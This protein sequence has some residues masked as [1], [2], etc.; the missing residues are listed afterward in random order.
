MKKNLLII[1][2]LSCN[3]I[4]YSQSFNQLIIGANNNGAI[5]STALDGSSPAV[6]NTGQS[7]QSYYNA[8]YNP[9]DEKLYMSWYY[10]IYSMNTDG[11]DFQ[12]LYSYPAGGMGD[13]IDID[14]LNGH[15][16]FTNTTEDF[17]YRIDLD[18]GNLTS[19]YG[20]SSNVGF[21]SQVQVDIQNNHLYFGEEIVAS[22]GLYR[23]NLDGTNRQTINNTEMPFFKT[24]PV[25]G[26][27]YYCVDGDF[28][29]CNLDGSN[30]II[31]LAGQSVSAFDIDFDADK[32]YYITWNNNLISTNLAGN[33]VTVLLQ[34][35][36]LTI[37]GSNLQA[38]Q[39]PV[40]V[41][42][43]NVSAD[44]SETNV[45]CHGDTT[46][47][48]DLTVSG[49][50][51]PYSYLWDNGEI[52]E[53]LSDLSA[54]TY[55]ITITDAN[56][57]T[58]TTSV[59]LTEPTAIDLSTDLTN[60][61]CHGDT[62]GTIDLTVSGGTNPYS[63]MWDN[64]QITEDLSDLSAGT[65]EVTV[66]DDNNCTIT[67]SVTL[68]EPTAIDLSTDLTNIT[69]H[70]GTNGA[71]DLTVS[72]GT[73]PYSYLWSNDETTQDLNN[74]SAGTYDVIVTDASSCTTTTSV[75]LTE[76]TAIDISTNV[77]SITIT[78]NA[79]GVNY[80]WL[81][82]DNDNA[83]ITGATNQSFT[84]IVNGNYAVIID[85]GTCSDT[86]ACV[87]I[88]SL[89]LDEVW[90]TELVEIYPN[91]TAGDVTITFEGTIAELTIRDATGKLVWSNEIQQNTTIS[92]NDYQKG[93]YFFE[94]KTATQTGIKKIVKQ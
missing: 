22:S 75:T 55:E 14:T 27:H 59:T 91:P 76:P 85:N 44:I 18:G 80:Q 89:S 48:I 93:I 78:A 6:I 13:G 9:V 72:N 62:I 37:N 92:L 71:I 2:I 90:N 38:L 47:A 68:T 45:T 1:L 53:D 7:Y 64:G 36:D 57:C 41:Y 49:G 42:T 26:H 74:L 65:Y 21:L 4:G 39:T 5:I 60:I 82:C 29:R 46:G 87:A 16:Y 3:L 88:N 52:T 8:K 20:G 11:S 19:I 84:P 51:S 32:V 24:Y 94:L 69:C 54:G 79:S 77:S 15:I 81:D 40:L 66:T 58:T 25:N 30:D 50:T 23:I 43:C 86:S 12:T 73:S 31:I 35:N 63:Y 70:G 67:A 10:G 34:P 17:I 33:N 28:H 56:S 61:T 83:F